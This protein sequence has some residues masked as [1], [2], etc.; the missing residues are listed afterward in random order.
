MTSLTSISTSLLM[1]MHVRW[2][3]VTFRTVSSIWTQVYTTLLTLP[4][5]L[6]TQEEVHAPHQSLATRCDLPIRVGVTRLE[7]AMRTG[8]P[9]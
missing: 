4:T 6:V 9:P 3:L 5:P 7:T 1:K 2:L 8:H